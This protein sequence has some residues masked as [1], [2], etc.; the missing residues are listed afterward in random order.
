MVTVQ[1]KIDI[2]LD[3]EVETD[4]L[5]DAT[6]RDIIAQQIKDYYMDDIADSAQVI[7]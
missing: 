7:G 2:E 5:M 3:I 6:L 4:E 1:I